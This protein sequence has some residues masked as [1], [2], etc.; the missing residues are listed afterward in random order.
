[1]CAS[2]VRESHGAQRMLEPK[3]DEEVITLTLTLTLWG[4][5]DMSGLMCS[6]KTK[7]GTGVGCHGTYEVRAIGSE[8]SAPYQGE[9]GSHV[10]G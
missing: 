7:Q 6:V 5:S 1:M 4:A 8:G 10:E 2:V 3:W 9:E